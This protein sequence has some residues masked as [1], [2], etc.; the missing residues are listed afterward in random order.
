MRDVI[1]ITL[2]FIGKLL[3]D[4]SLEDG[5]RMQ[6]YSKRSKYHLQFLV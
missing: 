5:I 1:L 3:F 4:T 6:S 2:P